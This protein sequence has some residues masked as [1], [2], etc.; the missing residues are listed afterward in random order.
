MS[1]LLQVAVGLTSILAALVAPPAQAQSEPALYILGGRNQEVNLGCINC[2]SYDQDS[3][4]NEYGK[5]G[6]QYQS[7]S[8]FNSYGPYGSPYSNDSACNPNATNPPIIVDSDGNFYGYL[9]INQNL[10]IADISGTRSF[11]SGLCR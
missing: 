11:L 4:W 6:S 2:D 7:A 8:I 1:R 10:E 9:S 5:H 3:I